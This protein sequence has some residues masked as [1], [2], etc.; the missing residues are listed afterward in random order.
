MCNRFVLHGNL[1]SDTNAV[2]QIMEACGMP[3]RFEGGA[4]PTEAPTLVTPAGRFQ[5][6]DA[7]RSVFSCKADTRQT[8]HARHS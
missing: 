8:P 1:G 2:R 5:G 6:L 4:D 3:Y 7:I